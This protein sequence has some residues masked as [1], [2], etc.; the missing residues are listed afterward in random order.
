AQHSSPEVRIAQ[1]QILAAQHKLE[2]ARQSLQRAMDD[3]HDLAM[4]ARIHEVRADLESQ[5]G[6]V[7]RAAA[8]RAEAERLR[9]EAK[10][11]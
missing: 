3:C 5:A 4:L 9:R 10:Q 6:Q 11:P 8:E 1:A 2:S 7:H